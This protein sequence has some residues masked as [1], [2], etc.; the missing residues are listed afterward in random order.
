MVTYKTKFNFFLLLVSCIVVF[1]SCDKKRTPIAYEF[2]KGFSG[3]VTVKFEKKNAP[4]L[5]KVNGF[6]HIQISDSGFAETS[7]KI[8]EGWAEDKYYWMDGDKEFLL[9]EFSEDKTTM[10]H[11]ETYR[12]AD[13]RNFVNPDTLTIGKEYTL[14]DGSKITKQDNNGG[15]SRTGGRQLLY[16]FYVSKDRENTWDF[17]KNKLPPIPAEHSTW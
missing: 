14:Y 2:P 9:R 6:Y 16:T 1:S 5:E 15:I 10:I 17:T 12:D 7:S 13:Y 11:G 8:G 3:W 4:P